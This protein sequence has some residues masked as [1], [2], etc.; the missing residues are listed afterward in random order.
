M[1]IQ[2]LQNMKNPDI[3]ICEIIESKMNEIMNKIN[4]TD[5]IIDADKL[6]PMWKL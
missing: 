4:Q 1:M 2:V 3:T 5:S 6:L